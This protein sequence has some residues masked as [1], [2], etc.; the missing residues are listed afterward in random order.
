MLAPKKQK[1]R[2]WQRGDQIRGIATQ[3]NKVSFGTYG[4]KTQEAAWI[5]SRQIESARRA[6][7]HHLQRGAKYWIRIFPDKP[8]TSKSGEIPMGKGKG[9]VDHYVAVVKPGN[10]L[11][12]LEG[13][14]ANRAKEAFRLASHKLPVKCTFITK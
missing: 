11:F 4:L 5:T 1:H 3:G 8:M 6:I 9:A 2:K 12:E 10:I 7:V 13:I 14:E